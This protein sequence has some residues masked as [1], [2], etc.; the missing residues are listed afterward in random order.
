MNNL[1]VAGNNNVVIQGVNG[2]NINVTVNGIDEKISNNLASFLALFEKSNLKSFL[3]DDRVYDFNAIDQSNFAYILGRAGKNKMLPIGLKNDLLKVEEDDWIERLRRALDAHTVPTGETA[4]SIFTHFGWLIE[5]YL[6]KFKAIEDE[7]PPLRRLS[8]LAEAYQSSLRFLCFVQLSQLLQRG[9]KVKH[10]VISDFIRHDKEQ[11]LSFDYCNLLIVATGF[12]KDKE[13]ESFMPEIDEFV[14]ELS[15]AGSD[16]YATNLFLENVRNSIL[17]KS[18]NQ[19]DDL[20]AIIDEYLTAL[21]EWLSK[22]TFISEYKMVSIK[23]INLD[24]RLGTVPLFRHVFGELNS[25]Y[26]ESRDM[27]VPIVGAYTF[28]QSI[29]LLKGKNI[30]Q[31]LELIDKEGTYISLSPLVIDQSIYAG[32]QKQTPEIYFFSGFDDSRKTYTYSQYRNELPI[33]DAEV[34]TNKYLDIGKSSKPAALYTL[35]K[36]LNDLLEPFK[37]PDQ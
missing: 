18:F 25:M 10:P 12:L 2:G 30:A 19:Q 4:N 37:F 23:E 22:L 6:L 13:V 8:F 3:A 7:G 16:L 15:D 32:D 20:H 1:E 28:N 31:S 9:L 26:E 35:F 21:V 17:K 33:S 29:L 27:K 5:A 14:H 34:N 24:Y 11:M 36:C